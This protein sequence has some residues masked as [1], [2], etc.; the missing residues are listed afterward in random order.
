LRLFE[1]EAKTVLS[2]YGV[3]TPKGAVAKTPL[4][5]RQIAEKLASPV[6][7][8]AQVLIAGRGKTGGILFADTL[9]QAEEAAEKL[10]AASIKGNPVKQV[11][12]EQKLGIRKELYFAV[13]VDR[14]NRSYVAVASASG[15]IDIEQVAQETPEKILKLQ[16][17][18]ALG[19]RL[20]HA[21]QLA[22]SLGYS[23][24]QM[25]ELAEGLHKIY[26]AGAALDA[27]LIECNPLAETTEGKFV[28][29]DARIIIDDNALL[30]HP[31][32]LKRQLQMQRDLDPQE[33]EAFQAG[34]EYVKLDGDVGVVGNGAGLVMA[35]LDLIS[36]FGGK[37]AN[38]LDLGGGA[39]IER[40]VKALKIVQANPR[41]KVT[42]VNV[43]GGMTRCDEVA[44]AIVEAVKENGSKK[45][46]VVRLVGT[47]EAEGKWT[48][49]AAG[50]PV[51]DSMEEAAQK[52]VALAKEV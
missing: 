46:M 23:G 30:R 25:S 47:M 20:Y 4:Q 17:N 32:F 36:L 2:S 29:A 49:S 13:T 16:I 39:S 43:L 10:F 51:F 50:F 21:R 41:V 7:V 26:L 5:A 3:P 34:L 45:P 24:N 31:D 9:T 1:F 8:K 40:I 52:A 48:L 37:A 42:F 38:F 44:E 28:A 11:L 15:G 14:P 18:P 33:A 12:V 22:S 19:F 27:E 35:T 6:A